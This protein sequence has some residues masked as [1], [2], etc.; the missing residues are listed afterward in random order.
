[1]SNLTPA[2]EA[3]LNAMIARHQRIRSRLPRQYQQELDQL[4]ALVKRRFLA[5]LPAV[6]LWASTTHLVSEI[7]SGL[8]ALEVASLA[9]YVLGGIAADATPIFKL[10]YVQLENQLQTENRQFT[11]IS[12]IMKTKHETVRTSLSNVR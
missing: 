6:N 3:R 11:A 10:H 4:T 8:T 5:N 2:D 12:N 1:M 7:I 9:D